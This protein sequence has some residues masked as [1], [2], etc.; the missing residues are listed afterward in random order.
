MERS[1]RSGSEV[2][3]RDGNAL[4]NQHEHVIEVEQYATSPTEA[5][6]EK[7]TTESRS[8]DRYMH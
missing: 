4:L 6:D 1:A 8:G 3:D 2:L 7:C 5:E